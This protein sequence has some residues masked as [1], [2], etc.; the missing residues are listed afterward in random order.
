MLF[1]YAC[2][3]SR[4]HRGRRAERATVIAQS[5]PTRWLTVQATTVQTEKPSSQTVS[6]I[7]LCVCT[8]QCRLAVVVPRSEPLVCGH[9]LTATHRIYYYDFDH[10]VAP[11]ARRSIV[12]RTTAAF[13]G[14]FIYCGGGG[15][16]WTRH[17]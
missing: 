15:Y 10:V 6:S 3:P 17:K 11:T 16:R 2:G 1:G 9:T 4:R 8:L 12:P 5:S 7:M 13:I 14:G